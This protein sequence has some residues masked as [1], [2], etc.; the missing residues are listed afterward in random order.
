[1]LVIEHGEAAVAAL[2]ADETHRIDLLV[3]GDP[4]AREPRG[5]LAAVDEIETVVDATPVECIGGPNDGEFRRAD[6]NGCRPNGMYVVV[7]QQAADGSW[8][9]V[10]RR[11]VPR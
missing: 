10:E 5:L 4:D 9:V 8:R 2:E 11:Y 7:S 6:E 1:M 3:N